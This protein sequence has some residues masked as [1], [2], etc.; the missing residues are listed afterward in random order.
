MRTSYRSRIGT[1]RRRRGS[2]SIRAARSNTNTAPTKAR[3]SCIPGKRPG[4]WTTS[5][6]PNRTARRRA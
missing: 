4:R 1:S 2:I 6:T 5:C 3:C